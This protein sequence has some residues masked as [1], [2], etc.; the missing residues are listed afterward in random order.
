[1]TAPATPAKRP[2]K[3]RERWRLTRHDGNGYPPRTV[4]TY[5]SRIAATMAWAE[6]QAAEPDKLFAVEPGARHA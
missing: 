2:R 6:R 3:P 4:A 5:G 1:M